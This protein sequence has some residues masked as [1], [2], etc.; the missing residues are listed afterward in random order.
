MTWQGADEGGWTALIAGAYN[1][2]QA[3]VR[4]LL[5]ANANPSAADTKGKTALAWAQEKRYE[6]IVALLSHAAPTT[7]ARTTALEAVEE[8]PSEA[9]SP[10]ATSP[11]AAPAETGSPHAVSPHPALAETGSP[12]AIA[13][14]KTHPTAFDISDLT[15]EHARGADTPYLKAA[16]RDDQSL[17]AGGGGGAAAGTMAGAERVAGLRTVLFASR[18]L[19][20][21][22][23]A[24][25]WF[26]AEGIDSIAELAEVT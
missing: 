10:H 15:Y 16:G 22:G 11:R 3:T 14:E 7:A 20:R 9:S 5:A 4:A 18:L 21:Q 12:H 6:P 8:A 17:K 19:D 25:A 26:A 1:G 2:R 23:E 24:E 13:D